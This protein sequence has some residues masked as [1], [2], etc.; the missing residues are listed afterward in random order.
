M[1]FAILLDRFFHF[2]MFS[3][4]S[5]YLCGYKIAVSNYICKQ[6]L[7]SKVDDLTI[8]KN[9][10]QGR[11]PLMMSEFRGTLFISE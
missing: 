3:T 9:L 8:A 4:A 10:F 2:G 1:T 11:H 7:V 5:L 6:T